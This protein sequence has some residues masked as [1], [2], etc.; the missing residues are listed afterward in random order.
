MPKTVAPAYPD[1]ARH[2]AGSGS[3]TYGVGVFGVRPS[4][5]ARHPH[6]RLCARCTQWRVSSQ[7][8]AGQDIC[9]SCQQKIAAERPSCRRSSAGTATSARQQPSRWSRAELIVEVEWLLG[10]DS[11]V[12]IAHRLGYELDSL[13]R[14]LKRAGRVDLA[15]GLGRG[16]V[17]A[18]QK[19]VDR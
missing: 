17:A 5:A 10:W 7:Y 4:T 9:L 19:A 6:C 3:S 11:P 1:L 8:P 16:P 12:L 13:Q 14:R 2:A 18:P 15:R